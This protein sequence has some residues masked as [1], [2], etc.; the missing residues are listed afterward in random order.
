LKKGEHEFIMCNFAP[1]DMV[2]CS[3]RSFLPH[4]NYLTTRS[5]TLAYTMLPSPPSPKLTRQLELSTKLHRRRGI[6]CLLRQ[7]MGM[8]SRCA[9]RRPARHTLHIRPTQCH[10]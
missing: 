1:P 7:T 5:G 8:L 3:D 2:R 9:I 6:S 10:S 4:L